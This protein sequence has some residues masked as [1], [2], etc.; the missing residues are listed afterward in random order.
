VSTMT[1]R[2][3]EALALATAILAA[4][5]TPS[6]AVLS[7]DLP[8]TCAD[9]NALQNMALDGRLTAIKLYYK[10]F[11]QNIGD[12]DKQICLEAHVLLDGRFAVISETRDL[13]ETK[14]LPIDV[15]A[16][17]AMKGLCP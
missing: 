9:R 8:N 5:A 6:Q 7:L 16:R 11:I 17:M 10:G 4:A 2:K 1:F 15:A 13:I 12:R 3:A 14:C